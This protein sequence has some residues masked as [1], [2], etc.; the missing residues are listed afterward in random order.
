MANVINRAI[1]SFHMPMYFILSGYVLKSD[2]YS[3]SE[4]CKRKCK[5]ILLPAIIIY[6][7]TLPLYFISLDYSS[8]SIA[9]ILKTV[10]YINGDCAYNATIWFFFCMFQSLVVLK[11]LK[12]TEAKK[13]YLILLMIVCLLLSYIGYVAHWG[14]F[15]FLGIN[16]CLIGVFFMTFGV[17]LRRIQYEGGKL[18]L[19]AIS[20]PIWII[21]G[22]LLNSMVSMY[23]MNLGNF[24]LFI[25]SGITGSLVFFAVVHFI[26]SN[27][28]IKQ[29]SG[30]TI[31]VVCSHYV[32]ASAFL[33]VSL[34]LQI[35][36]TYVFD[37]ISA[38]F[39]LIMLILYKPVCKFLE[40]HM[41]LL[42][43][44]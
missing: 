5:R 2:S 28:T 32:L 43:G 23:G 26:H 7:L 17:L 37:V 33:K 38:L 30:W 24:W 31:F 11:I 14:F 36:G 20:L 19:G 12:I 15:N 35:G 9:S 13:V 6:V 16:K 42:L 27:K 3:L 34:R 18:L 4:Y 21:T 40:N 29:Y 25:V 1:Y 41:P 44:K 10:F 22:I 39:V 8:T